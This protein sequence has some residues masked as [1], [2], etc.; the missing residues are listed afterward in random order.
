MNVGKRLMGAVTLVLAAAALVASLVAAVGAWVVKQPVADK[1]TWVFER[2]EA[3]IDLAD[4]SLDHA[5]ASIARAIERLD[6]ARVEQAKIAQQPQSNST[7]RRMVARTVQQ[8]VA[9]QITDAQGQLHAVAEAAVVVNAVLEDL[10]AFPLLA[11]AGFDVAP[12]EA[13]NSGLAEVG[14]AAWELSRL[15][16]DSSASADDA[17]AQLSQLDRMLKSMQRL[18]ANYKTQV[19]GVRERT[20][21]LRDK[22]LWWITPTAIIVTVIC[23]W[24]AISQVSLLRHAWGWWRQAGRTTA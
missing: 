7:I 4:G 23:L 5:A 10:G 11:I 6:G 22:T 14:P 18:V 8:Q 20:D 21:E 12:L 17:S 19:A 16:G 15:F 2:V 1:A 9:P 3:K 24:I 13:M